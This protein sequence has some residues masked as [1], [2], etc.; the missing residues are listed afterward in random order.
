MSDR[1]NRSQTASGSGTPRTPASE[2]GTVKIKELRDKSAKGRFI[3]RDGGCVMCQHE[4]PKGTGATYNPKLSAAV[5][6]THVIPISKWSLFVRL[7]SDV[8]LQDLELRKPSEPKLELKRRINSLDNG[9]LLCG[10]HHSLFDSFVISITPELR[11]FSFS[12]ATDRLHGIPVKFDGTP[13]PH[14]ELLKI[15][16][17]SAAYHNMVASG[18]KAA[19]TVSDD[20]ETLLMRP[21]ELIEQMDTALLLNE[22]SS[23]LAVLEMAPPN[24]SPASVI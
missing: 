8:N 12:S 24:V 21:E 6:H 14:I 18:K 20:E 7:T 3:V 13:P 16:F 10:L 1:F 22:A 23:K 15:H 19:D 2:Q 4:H 5:H 9:M 17:T 11:F